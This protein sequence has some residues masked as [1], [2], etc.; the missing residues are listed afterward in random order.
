MKLHIA[1]PDTSSN[2]WPV[3][4]ARLTSLEHEIEDTEKTGMLKRWEFG[5]ELVKRRVTYKGRQIVPAQLMK[6]TMEKCELSRAEIT[7][8]IRFADRFPTRKETLDAIKSYP[9]WYQMFREGLVEKKRAVKKPREKKIVHSTAWLLGRLKQEVAKAWTQHLSLTREQVQ[10]V[11][12][13]HKA[14]GK[15]LEQIDQNDAAK[16]DR[17]IS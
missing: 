9:S 13:L 16:A 6:L 8:R 4:L 17:R 7:R 12:E 11:E 5:R 2:P 3:V 15:L 1:K 14:L 10:D